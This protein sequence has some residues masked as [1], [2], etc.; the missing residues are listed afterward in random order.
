[1]KHVTKALLFAAGC[2]FSSVLIP[3]DAK[4]SQ[5]IMVQKPAYAKWGRYAMSQTAKKY[6]NA[7]IIDYRHVGCKTVS[8]TETEETFKLWL[9]EGNREWGVFVRI[10][11]EPVTDKI[12][13]VSFQEVHR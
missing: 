9:K 11:F 2:S 12:I 8:P 3:L 6:P 10:L 5:P 4:A 7:S 1:M 13:S